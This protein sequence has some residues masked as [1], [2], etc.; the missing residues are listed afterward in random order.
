MRNLLAS[1]AFVVC[2]M[3]GTAM[4]TTPTGSDFDDTGDILARSQRHAN[5]EY[6]IMVQRAT[7]AAIYYMPA[8]A[9]NRFHQGYQAGWW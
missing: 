1:T 5:I 3:F 6:D 9:P 2:F 4:A 7:Q 8:V